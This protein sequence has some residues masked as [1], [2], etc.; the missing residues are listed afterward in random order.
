LAVKE[1]TMNIRTIFWSGL[2][3]AAIALCITGVMAAQHEGR[4]PVAAGGD[5]ADAI[6]VL[7]P[8]QGNDVTGV[9]KF[10]VVED[11]VRVQAHVT[12]LTP[13]KH[14]FH[15]HEFGDLSAPDG[16][17]A[18]DHFDPAGHDHGA[19]GD[20][21]RHVGDLGNL[22]ANA[23]G[24]AHYDRVDKH[25]ALSGEH[26]IIGR[27]LVV[28]ADPDD[29]VSQPTGAAGARVAVGVIGIAQKD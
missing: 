5:A 8:T 27:G 16:T 6:A 28:H 19:P 22:E 26:S 25:L 14:G 17:S 7:H 29:L 18:G 23:Q 1:K 24:I 12:G 3:V 10:T 20:E 9:V 15:V 11:G 2:A 13:G 4:S 21:V